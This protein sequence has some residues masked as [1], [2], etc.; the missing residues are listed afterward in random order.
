M[1]C[2]VH[3][4]IPVRIAGCGNRSKCCSP[5]V[6][7]PTAITKVLNT[8]G[9]MK[10]WELSNLLLLFISGSIIVPHHF[11]T[12]VSKFNRLRLKEMPNY[13]TGIKFGSLRQDIKGSEVI[14]IQ[15]R[16]HTYLHT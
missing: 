15:I 16:R 12:S 4:K 13:E 1:V 8:D 9:V 2:T 3:R 5:C 14:T 10:A 7:E 11:R 6:I